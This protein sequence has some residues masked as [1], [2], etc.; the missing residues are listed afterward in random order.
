M[1]WAALIGHPRASAQHSCECT[2]QAPAT[3]PP[4]HHLLLGQ[5]PAEG[6]AVNQ[7][8][9]LQGANG[10]RETWMAIDT[11]SAVGSKAA[12]AQAPVVFVTC[13]H[14]CAG[15][16]TKLTRKG[17]AGAAAALVA[18]GGHLAQGA[19]VPGGGR[20]LSQLAA[21]LGICLDVGLGSGG[22]AACDGT[23]RSDAL[24]Q[25]LGRKVSKGHVRVLMQACGAQEWDGEA[26]KVSC[27]RV[28]CGSLVHVQ[29]LDNVGPLQSGA[30]TLEEL[31]LAIAVVA[32]EVVHSG[33]EL[34][35]GGVLSGGVCVRLAVLSFPLVEQGAAVL[36]AG[37]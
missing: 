17:P 20:R 30:L 8:L 25:A 13:G 34:G 29:C 22:G 32:D 3:A 6:G 28:L 24:H 2:Q 19:P 31:G 37:G 12:L 10:C 33:A 27:D 35:K 16:P 5:V 23:L 18:C 7:R 11:R 14:H 21:G 1:R 36:R 26:G 9:A 4:P 15:A